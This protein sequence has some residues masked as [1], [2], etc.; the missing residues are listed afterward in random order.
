M[1]EKQGRELEDQTA[2]KEPCDRAVKE[3]GK[4]WLNNY[5][6]HDCSLNADWE[7][8]HIL[9]LKQVWEMSHSS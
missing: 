4:A 3:Q 2:G 5:V 1:E 9:N 6:Q 8:L 7:V